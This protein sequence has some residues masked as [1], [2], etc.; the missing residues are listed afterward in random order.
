MLLRISFLALIPRFLGASLAQDLQS[1]TPPEEAA[2][3]AQVVEDDPEDFIN[4]FKDWQSP[5]YPLIFRNPLPIPP[6]KQPKM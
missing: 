3:L 1:N 5:E 2:I 6:V 4:M